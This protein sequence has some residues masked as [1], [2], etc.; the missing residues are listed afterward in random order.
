M[1]LASLTFLGLPNLVP[2]ARPSFDVQHVATA[3]SGEPASDFFGEPCG[4]LLRCR[5]VMAR[6]APWILRGMAGLAPATGRS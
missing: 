4:G 3:A 2:L 1:C 5:E 6:R